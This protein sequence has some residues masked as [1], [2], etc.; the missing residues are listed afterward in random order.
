MFC[1]K[2]IFFIWEVEYVILEIDGLLSV[3]LKFDYVKLIRSDLQL[4]FFEFVLFIVFV[5]DGCLFLKNLFQLGFDED[6][7]KIQLKKQGFIDYKQVFYV[8][9]QQGSIFFIEF[10]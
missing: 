5:S 6:W 9:W 10:Y 1:L 4:F 7:L 8:E 2:D 3:L